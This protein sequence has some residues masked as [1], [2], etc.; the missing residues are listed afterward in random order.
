MSQVT[1]K[2]YQDAAAALRNRRLIALGIRSITPVVAALDAANNAIEIA[3]KRKDI[4]NRQTSL[5]EE[6]LSFNQLAWP[7]E[8]SLISEAQ[9]AQGW[10]TQLD[11]VVGRAQVPVKA[12]FAKERRQTKRGYSRYNSA[13]MVGQLNKLCLA[14]EIS[15][16]SAK[17]LAFRT[18]IGKEQAQNDRNWNRRSEVAGLGKGLSSQITSFYSAAGSGLAGAQQ[19]AGMAFNNAL[20]RLGSVVDGYMNQNPFVSQEFINRQ[21]NQ[22]NQPFSGVNGTAGPYPAVNFGE[23]SQFGGSGITTLQDS[24]IMSPQSI[25]N[26]ESEA[27]SVGKQDYGNTVFHQN[28]PIEPDST[29]SSIPEKR[30]RVRGGGLFGGGSVL[31]KFDSSD[32]DYTNAN[33][34]DLPITDIHGYEA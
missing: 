27:V 3:K 7:C 19:A 1:D 12:T 11:I 8:Q 22:G 14:E 18:E 26:S 5:A 32:I 20:G 30:F 13:A 16:S 29:V 6:Q 28:Y 2:G 33:S 9:S 15:V 17:N 34:T 10:D 4:A 31:V 24:M 23:A 25:V 21:M